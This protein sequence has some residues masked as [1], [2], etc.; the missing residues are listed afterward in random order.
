M[1]YFNEFINFFILYF[2]LSLTIYSTYFHFIK[3]NT[4]CFLFFYTN[5]NLMKNSLKADASLI[6]TIITIILIYYKDNA[7]LLNKILNFIINLL[8]R[9]KQIDIYK[10]ITFQ[11]AV[12]IQYLFY[13]LL[14]LKED[15]LEKIRK[16]NSA[17]LKNFKTLNE[18]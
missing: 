14:H 4:Y 6:S 3:V 1:S 9:E 15:L 10:K 5:M 8:T 16:N 2:L 12:K 11:L 13:L 7:I 17:N 18:R